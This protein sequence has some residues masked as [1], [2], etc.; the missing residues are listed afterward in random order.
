MRI[1]VLFLCV[2]VLAGCGPSDWS[3]VPSGPPDPARMISEGYQYQ[4]ATAQAA[5]TQEAAS[6]LVQ[7]KAEKRA[8]REIAAVFAPVQADETRVA[9]AATVQQ[10]NIE[11]GQ[12]TATQAAAQ[13]TATYQAGQATGTAAAAE[14]DTT[15]RQTMAWVWAWVPIIGVMFA[16]GVF[17]MG[18]LVLAGEEQKVRLEARRQQ[19]DEARRWSAAALASG[20]QPK[21]LEV[22]AGGDHLI[23]FMPDKPDA[24]KTAD[25]QQELIAFVGRA[26]AIAGPFAN[27]FPRWNGM[28]YSSEDWVKYTDWLVE[29]GALEK[30][31]G[32]GNRLAG[33]YTSL[34][35]LKTDLVAGVLVV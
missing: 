12:A 13:T 26:I 20:Q 24:P 19:M 21:V 35:Q 2:L 28:G 30:K 25:P 29:A 33:G 23:R 5:R 11:A 22:S 15:R 27:R 3:G 7:L 6:T 16:L 14:L 32:S 34:G 1:P 31:N 9:L 17:V 10:L 18:A 4:T 8:E